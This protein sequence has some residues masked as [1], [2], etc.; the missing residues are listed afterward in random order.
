MPGSYWYKAPIGSATDNVDET[1]HQIT[2]INSGST[3]LNGDYTAGKFSAISD[4]PTYQ[5]NSD[6][7]WDTQAIWTPV[8][9]SPACPV[10]G[11]SGAN[12][13]INNIVTVNTDRKFAYSTN[14]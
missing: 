13:I 6:G 8:G 10:G 7:N 14:G 9:T 1:I 11:P 5:T 3:S 12:V 4:V 2:F